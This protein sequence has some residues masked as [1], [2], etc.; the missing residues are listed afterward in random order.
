MKLPAAFDKLAKDGFTFSI[1]HQPAEDY[2]WKVSA[3]A[4]TA[5]AASLGHGQ[6]L[7]EAVVGLQEALRQYDW[8]YVGEEASA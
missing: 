5:Q 7:D 3:Q 4:P 1:T 2:L 6:S 8:P